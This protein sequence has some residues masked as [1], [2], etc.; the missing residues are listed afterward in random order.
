[1]GGSYKMK[2]RD[3]HSSLSLFFLAVTFAAI[4]VC[5]SVFAAVI[6]PY[7]LPLLSALVLWWTDPERAA[8]PV[9]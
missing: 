3:Q 2:R 8:R 6:F 1:M 4:S 5:P 9:H 7:V